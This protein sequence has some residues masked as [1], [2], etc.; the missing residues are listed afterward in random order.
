MKI[1]IALIM[2]LPIAFSGQRDKYYSLEDFQKVD[3]IDFHIHINTQRTAFT[4]Q[5]KKDGFRLYNIVVD[6][7][8][9]DYLNKQFDN[10][11]FQKNNFPNLFEFG[12][13][14]S[15]DGWD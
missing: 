14:F 7:G 13:S 3:K 8:D 2:V 5:A 11:Y 6:T 15:L 9:K 4:E 1:K 12:T 10:C